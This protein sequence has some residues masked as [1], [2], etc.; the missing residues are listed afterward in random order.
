M[1]KR[2]YMFGKRIIHSL[3]FYWFPFLAY[4][5]IIFFLSHQNDPTAGLDVPVNDKIIHAGEFF[6]LQFLAIR[7]FCYARSAGDV[8]RWFLLSIMF[9]CL[10]ALS[11]EFHQLF[12]ADRDGSFGDIF[13][14][15]SGIVLCVGTHRVINFLR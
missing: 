1:S 6:V 13:A 10:Y 4:V 14:D 5:G 12:I 8:K 7:A 11:D 9:S 3:L 15:Y 2:G